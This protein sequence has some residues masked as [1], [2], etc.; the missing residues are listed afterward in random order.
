MKLKS[1]YKEIDDM[2]KPVT[3]SVYDAVTSQIEWKVDEKLTIYTDHLYEEL[4]KVIENAIK[5]N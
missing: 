2:Y 3:I 5:V 4:V 1:K